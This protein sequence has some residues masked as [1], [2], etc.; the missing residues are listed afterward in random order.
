MVLGSFALASMGALAHRLRGSCDW[1]VIVLARGCLQLLLSGLLAYL[2]GVSLVFW[3]PPILWVRSVAGSLGMLF[4]FYAYT[5][6]PVAEALVLNNMFPIWV[7]V[8]S[9]PLLKQFPSPPVWLAVTTATA[10]VVLMQQPRFLEGNFAALVAL[11]SSLCTAIAMLALNR[12]QGVDARAI[13]VHFS[14][15]AVLMCLVSYFPLALGRE[16]ATIPPAFTENAPP[17]DGVVL[18]VFLLLGVGIMALLAQVGITKAFT[19]GNAAK[20]SVVNLTQTV[21]AMTFHVFCFGHSMDLTKYLGMALILVPT[22]WLM[23]ERVRAQ[24]HGTQDRMVAKQQFK[25][26][27]NDNDARS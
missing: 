2:A 16:T 12:L 6:L 5:R 14:A 10:G 20:V 11:A 19:T 26:G 22:A 27:E 13:I 18:V 21:F 23:L 1:Q 8:L 3:R 4:M 25:N 17:T 15:V 7:A 9:W 24:T